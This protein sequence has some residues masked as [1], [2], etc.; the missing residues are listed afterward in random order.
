MAYERAF[1]T[2]LVA[3]V[4]GIFKRLGTLNFPIKFRG[5]ED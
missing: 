1:A 4:D 3:E 5:D 2:I